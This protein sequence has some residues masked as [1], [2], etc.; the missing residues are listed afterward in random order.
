MHERIEVQLTLVYPQSAEDN[1]LQTSFDV[2]ATA[3]VREY[4]HTASEP[5]EILIEDIEIDAVRLWSTMLG[6][7]G[8]MWHGE[9][10][11]SAMVAIE[12]QRMLDWLN[13][14][15]DDNDHWTDRIRAAVLA[16]HDTALAVY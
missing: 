15:L 13:S 8:S 11:V 7:F 12:R 10:P 1:E 14:Q 3:T 2:T 5:G 4:G 16:K 9:T 6:R